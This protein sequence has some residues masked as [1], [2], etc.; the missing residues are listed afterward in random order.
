MVLPL[1]LPTC[2]TCFTYL[3]V[4]KPSV[5]FGQ[6]LL[7][8]LKVRIAILKYCFSNKINLFIIGMNHVINTMINETYQ[9]E[10]QM[11]QHF[12]NY[13][14]LKSNWLFIGFTNNDKT[15]HRT[16]NNPKQKWFKN[17]YFKNWLYWRKRLWSNFRK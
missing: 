9:F 14:T 7:L 6:H 11:L 15:C 8:L 12:N 2:M 13:Q 17:N 3:S 5:H 1:W 4:F 10:D 16:F